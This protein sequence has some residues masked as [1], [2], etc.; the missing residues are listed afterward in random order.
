MERLLFV[1]LFI[2]YS[3]AALFLLALF[4]SSQSLAETNKSIDNYFYIGKMESHNKDFTLFFKPRD[5]AILAKG[6]NSNYINNYPQ[7]LY[8]Y[9]NNSNKEISLVSYDWFPKTAK[10]FLLDYDYPVFPDDFA[11]YLL[12]DNNTLIMVS[13]I[14]DINKNFTYDIKKNKLNIYQKK[15]DLSFIIST[16]SRNCGYTSLNSEFSCNIYKPLIANNVIN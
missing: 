14:K 5:K 9:D 13:T 4:Y 3:S 12:K 1:I 7:D 8:F 2:F 15:S 16:Y 11:Y 6:K 10:K